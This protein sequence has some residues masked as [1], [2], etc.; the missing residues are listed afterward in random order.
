[1]CIRLNHHQTQIG[2]QPASTNGKPLGWPSESNMIFLL[3]SSTQGDSPGEGSVSQ[4]AIN[5]T[6]V[7]YDLASS[8]INV[9]YWSPAEPDKSNASTH[10]SLQAYEEQCLHQLMA[11]KIYFNHICTF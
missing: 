11:R 4:Y 3:S 6:T 2:M 1:M 5:T 10:N 9:S 7:I 8:F